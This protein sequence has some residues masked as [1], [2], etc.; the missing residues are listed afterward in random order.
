LK[1][2]DKI[3]YQKTDKLIFKS[4]RQKTVASETRQF[5]FGNLMAG[6]KLDS[7]G[8]HVAPIA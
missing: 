1:S 6:E 8:Y 4:H 3:V 7:L 2:S 5:K